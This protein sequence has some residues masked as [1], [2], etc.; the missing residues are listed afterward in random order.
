[1]LSGQEFSG[2]SCWQEF[3]GDGVELSS[4]LLLAGRDSLVRRPLGCASG[5]DHA[6]LRF[7][8]GFAGAQRAGILGA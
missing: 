7:W 6:G 8:K 5:A 2:I 1:M 3:A 4:S